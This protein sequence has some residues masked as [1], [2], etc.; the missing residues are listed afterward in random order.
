VDQDVPGSGRRGCRTWIRYQQ[1]AHTEIL[2]A[3]RLDTVADSENKQVGPVTLKG[4]PWTLL[5]V[6]VLLWLEALGVVVLAVTQIVDTITQVAQSLAWAVTMDLVLVVLAGLFGWLGWLLLN[7]RAGARNPSVAVHLLAL[8]I[9]Y[10]MAKGG[11]VVLGVGAIVVCVVAVFLLVSP[12][13]TR[14]LGIK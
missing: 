10:F 7:R 5:A 14:A 13:T 11:L 3:G 9:G 6:V 12:A 8:A 4:L 1:R 2:P